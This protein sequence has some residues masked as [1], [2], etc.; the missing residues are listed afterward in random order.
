MVM[1]QLGYFFRI[2][3]FA[4]SACCAVLSTSELSNKKNTGWKG[5]FLLMSPM[6]RAEIGSSAT[7]SG[8]TGR[9]SETG[10][11]GAGGRFASEAA[12]GGGGVGLA[13]GGCGFLHATVSASIAA[14]TNRKCCLY[15]VISSQSLLG[16]S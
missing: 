16:R 3:A 7:G 8:G 4:L 1:T 2:S 9:G 10:V 12:E 14:I 15:F 6:S 5:E 11:G 13:I